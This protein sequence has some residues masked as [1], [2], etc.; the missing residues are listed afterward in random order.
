MKTQIV[1]SWRA[2]RLRACRLLDTGR[3]LRAP[4]MLVLH[5]AQPPHRVLTLSR[6]RRTA[7]RSFT[8]PGDGAGLEDR[9]L[10]GSW[11]L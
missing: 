2:R 11:N 5:W 6:M 3:G 10:R 8:A 4:K 7:Y 9:T 1:A